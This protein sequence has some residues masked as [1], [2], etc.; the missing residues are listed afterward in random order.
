MQ[1]CKP[2]STPIDP[3]HRLIATSD[4]DDKADATAY[5]QIIGSLM[6]LVTATRP[7]LAYTITHLS[8]FNSN[9]STAHMSA[10]KRV[11]RYLQKTKEKSLLFPFGSDLK[12][13]AYNDASYGN[14][15]DTRRSFSGYLF[16]LGDST[17]SWRSRKQRSV[18]T[19]TCEAEYMALAMTTKHHLWLTRG[20]KELLKNDIPHAVFC[21]SNSA[22]DVANNPKL[23]DRT[24]HI[25]IAYHFTRECVQN[26]SVNLMYVTTAENLADICTKGLVKQTH[27]HLCTCIFGTK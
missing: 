22:I 27:D 16:R 7:D 8:Q 26:G 19:S 9:P 3:N 10:A 2:V 6:Y 13:S 14:C 1:D 24:K 17:I 20:L 11:L 23:N 18:A 12:L 15:Y 5:Q 21:D 25:D 4:E